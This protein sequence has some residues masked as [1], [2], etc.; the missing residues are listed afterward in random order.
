MKMGFWLLLGVTVVAFG[1]VLR[2]AYIRWQAR[3]QAE[4]ERAFEAEGLLNVSD[5]VE[6]EP[7]A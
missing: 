6:L 7:G 3:Q 4:E 5:Q 1:W 2:L